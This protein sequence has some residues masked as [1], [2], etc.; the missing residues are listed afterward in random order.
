MDNTTKI[1][2]VLLAQGYVIHK[3]ESWNSFSKTRKDLFGIIDFLAPELT[4]N[5]ELWMSTGAKFEIWAYNKTTKI[6][7]IKSAGIQ[8]YPV[9]KLEFYDS[10]L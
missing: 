8:T 9:E 10:V 2:E 7:K 4:R 6:I 5:I 1:K 3:V